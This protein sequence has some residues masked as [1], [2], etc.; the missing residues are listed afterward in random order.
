MACGTNAVPF[1]GLNSHTSA[2]YVNYGGHVFQ[3]AQ[4]NPSSVVRN[5]FHLPKEKELMRGLFE[6]FI[7]D[8]ETGTV[9]DPGLFVAKDDQTARMKAWIASKLDGDLDNYDF[10]VRRLGDVRNKKSVQEVKVIP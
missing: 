5:D 6:V 1:N 9:V 2:G 8:P 7:V 4:P 10:I 3:L